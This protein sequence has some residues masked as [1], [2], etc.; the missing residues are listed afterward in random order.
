MEDKTDPNVLVIR[1]RVRA[2]L[3]EL[4]RLLP[5]AHKIIVNGGT[6][7]PYRLRVSRE[8]WRQAVVTMTEAID[9]T[10]FKD[11]V[12]VKQGRKRH[13]AYMRVWSAMLWLEEAVGGRRRRRSA[14]AKRA[15]GELTDVFP[16]TV[17]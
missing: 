10:N 11:S 4:N 15:S 1:A 17:E 5:K 13:D 8:A 12:T 14:R 2:D 6:D 3:E 16:F 7:Y 9:Y